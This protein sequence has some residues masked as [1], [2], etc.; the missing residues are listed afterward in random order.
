MINK[1]DVEVEEFTEKAVIL[2]NNTTGD[3]YTIEADVIVL[4]TGFKATEFLYP[5]NVKGM[6]YVSMYLWNRFCCLHFVFNSK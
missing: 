5:M 1:K 3:F 4:A 2:K 6:I